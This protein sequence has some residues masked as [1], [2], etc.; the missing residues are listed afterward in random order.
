MLFTKNGLC[1]KL[2]LIAVLVDAFHDDID[3]FTH[4]C[5]RDD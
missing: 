1:L 4:L 5:F 3:P 2:K